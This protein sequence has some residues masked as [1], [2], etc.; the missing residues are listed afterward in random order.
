MRGDA[1][2]GQ[3]VFDLVVVALVGLPAL[4][5]VTVAAVAISLTSRGPILFRQVRIGQFGRPYQILK[6]RTMVGRPDNALIPDPA[7]ITR[8]GR[9]LRRTSADELPQL[10]Q[11]ARGQMSIV[12]PRPGLPGQAER[13][14]VRQRARLN[15]RPGIT[16]LAQVTGRNRLNWAERI[17]FDLEYI[18]AASLRT[19]VAIL[20]RTFGVVLRGSG[21]SGHPADDPILGSGRGD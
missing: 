12:G 6:L 13:L 9:L 10:W 4:V 19:D 16:G 2:A 7:R 1:Y 3:R 17:E 20:V 21:V 15:V 18:D 5:A 8:V 11:V 14:T